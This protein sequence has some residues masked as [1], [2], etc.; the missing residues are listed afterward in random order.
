MENYDYMKNKHPIP[1]RLREMAQKYRDIYNNP[2]FKAILDFDK[3]NCI[4]TSCGTVA[5]HGGW[6]GQALEIDVDPGAAGYFIRGADKL[7]KF[8]FNDDSAHEESLENWARNNPK[9]WGNSKG[10]FMFSAC[11][12][13]AFGFCV[14]SGHECT[15][16]SIAD[17]YYMVANN[18]DEML[19]KNQ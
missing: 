3:S 18:I 17:H 13:E 5:C 7:S 14:S 10:L 1:E 6:A 11:G 16:E 9:L 15:L 19:S 8:L 2:E 4:K 12:Y